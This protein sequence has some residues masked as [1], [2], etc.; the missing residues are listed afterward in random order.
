ME[1]SV[2]NKNYKLWGVW[3]AAS[4]TGGSKQI[5]NGQ[6]YLPTVKW[7]SPV[8]VVIAKKDGRWRVCVGFNTLNVAAKKYPY[9]LPFIDEILDIVVG[10]ERYSVCDRFSGYF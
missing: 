8:V 6:I 1:L 4:P 10:Y 2:S 3:V 5:T 9:P 7:A